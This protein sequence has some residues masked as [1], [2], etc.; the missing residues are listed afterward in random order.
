MDLGRTGIWTHALD[1]QPVGRAQE[2]VGELESLGYGAVWIPEAVGREALSSSALLLPGGER[3]VVATGIANLWARD[4]M[5]M[6][7][8]H[9]TLTSAFPDRFLL[10]I[11]VSH[12]PAVDGLRGHRYEKPVATMRAYLDAMDSAPLLRRPAP[13]GAGAGAGRPRSEDAGARRR[14]G[15]RGPP[16]LRAPRAHGSGPGGAR[17]RP[18]PGARAGRR[19]GD[20]PD[21]RPGGG[22]SPH[23]H[24]PHP[25]QLHEQPPSPGLV[26]GGP[27]PAGQRP[28]GGRHRG[29]GRRGAGGARGW[30]STAPP[31]PTTCASRSSTPT[32]GR[33]PSR[34]GAG[35][36]PWG[37]PPPP[38][39]AAAGSGRSSPPA[40]ASVGAGP[41]PQPR[42]AGRRTATTAATTRRT[43]PV[44]RA[45]DTSATRP[46]RV[47]P[48]RTEHH[49]PVVRSAGPR[50]SRLARLDDVGRGG[51]QHG[52]RPGQAQGPGVALVPGPDEAHGQGQRDG[53]GH[54]DAAQGGRQGR[55]HG[56]PDELAHEVPERG[57]PQVDDGQDRDPGQGTERQPA[58]EEAEG[59]GAEF[60]PPQ[61]HERRIGRP[62]AQLERVSPGRRRKGD[63]RGGGHERRCPSGQPST[64]ALEGC[65]YPRPRPVVPVMGDVTDAHPSEGVW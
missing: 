16:L 7:A 39:R 6:S 10:G 61:S 53:H 2:L 22:P 59:E 38:A 1:M 64:P 5:A 40:P 19:A 49:G 28:A 63:G 24:L 58:H 30:P 51:R 26:R 8:G 3:I 20:R 50:R 27:G 44:R 55:G 41:A 47:E 54:H 17:S 23:G 43:A 18:D 52:C 42:R 12:Q 57:E 34:A 25:P 56:L 32:C 4:A 9:K 65:V 29:L 60:A 45:P 15:R 21:D 11:G 14:A 62:A 36:P 31:A 35:W 48:P 37:A 46:E 13:R 33:R